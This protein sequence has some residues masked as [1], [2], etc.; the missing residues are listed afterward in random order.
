MRIKE[1]VFSDIGSTAKTAPA[2]K[3]GA[4]SIFASELSKQEVEASSYTQEVEELRRDIEQAGDQLE[5]EPNL[6][7]F[8]KFR[9]LLSRLAKRISAEAYRLEKVGGTPQNPR[10]Y[11]VITVI[12][13]EADKLYN[14]IVNEHR[15]RMAITAK[16]IGI[17]GLVVDLIT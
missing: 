14:L 12:D 17:K 2:L 9:N 8:Q 4:S 13:K 11:E 10:Y 1:K 6:N 16:V 5:K 3:N 15:D 7:N